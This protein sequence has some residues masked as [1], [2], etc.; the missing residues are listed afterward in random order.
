MRRPI[1]LMAGL[2]LALAFVVSSAAALPLPV[3]IMVEVV[4]LLGLIL[5]LAAILR[6]ER[7]RFSY[8]RDLIDQRDSATE[9]GQ[10]PKLELVAGRRRRT[11]D[12]TGL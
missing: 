5:V 3:L 2:P 4:C 1:L 9:P 10:R 12:T 8:L 7:Q 6:L 11:E